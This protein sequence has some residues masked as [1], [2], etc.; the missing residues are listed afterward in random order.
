MSA[1]IAAG[2]WLVGGAIL[3]GAYLGAEASKDAASQ[4]AGASDRSAQLQNEQYLQSR[5]DLS[6]YREAAVGEEIWNYDQDAFDRDLAAW[7]QVQS[8]TLPGGALPA[9]LI[10]QLRTSPKPTLENYKTDVSGYT[11]GALNT[12]ADYGPSRVS[13][14]D[15]IPASDIPEYQRSVIGDLPAIDQRVSDFGYSGDIPQFNVQGDIPEFDS[16]QF[17]IYKDPS[18]EWRKEEM[19]RGLDR[20]AGATG[21]VTSGNRLEAIMDRTGEMASQEYG[22]ARDRMVQ[23]Y[24]IR[25]ENEATQYGRDVYG[26]GEGRKREADIYGRAAGEYGL[27]RGAEDAR[28]GRGVD[29]YG[30]TYGR[31][32]DQYGRDLTAYNAATSREGQLYGR[33]VDAYGRAYGAEGDYLN[34]LA[35]LSNIGQTATNTGVNAGASAARTGGAAITAA[36]QTRAAGT[37]GQTAAYTGAI[38]DLTSLYAMNQYGQPPP[39]QNYYN[40]YGP[41]EPMQPGF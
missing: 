2:T 14:G 8:G 27:T 38:G 25:R 18:Y 15:Y 29:E 3:G 26:Y 22:A 13:E 37:L 16:T 12:L 5:Q 1:G 4:S 30:R 33:G 20:T 10:Q 11:G 6:P 9:A 17:D 35:A 23:D 39:I 7:E 21:K 40:N 41:Y 24:G 31:D 36:G 19:L 34:R 28:Y 32:V